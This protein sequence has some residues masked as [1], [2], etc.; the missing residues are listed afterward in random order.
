MAAG[1]GASTPYGA[2]RVLARGSQLDARAPKAEQ[3]EHGHHHRDRI[4]VR[5]DAPV[6]FAQ[7]QPIVES[8][9]HVRPDDHD[10]QRLPQHRRRFPPYAGDH[11]V[12]R[13]VGSDDRLGDAG[14][15]HVRNEQ[16][17]NGEPEHQLYELPGGHAQRPAAPKSVDAEQSV[18]DQRRVQDDRARHVLPDRLHHAQQRF[19]RVDRKDAERVVA[20]M[21]RD[22][23]GQNESA[24]DAKNAKGPGVEADGSGGKRM[25]RLHETDYR[26]CGR[27]GPATPASDRR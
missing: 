13:G 23:G 1:C 3:C 16:Q 25:R 4:E 14:G 6:A 8:D 2:V 22:V 17:R 19:L 26:S 5:E 15:E 24:A 9:Q 12:I 20:E 11:R 21:R 10:E 7:P 18:K 27:I